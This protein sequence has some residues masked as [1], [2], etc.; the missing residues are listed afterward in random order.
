[1]NANMPKIPTQ[2]LDDANSRQL[3]NIAEQIASVMSEECNEVI[4]DDEEKTI[5]NGFHCLN[6]NCGYPDF[7]EKRFERGEELGEWFQSPHECNDV[8]KYLPKRA[9]FFS[10]LLFIYEITGFFGDYYF[11]NIMRLYDDYYIFSLDE[12]ALNV[13]EKVV[14]KDQPKKLT[15]R[16][17]Y[18]QVTESNGNKVLRDIDFKSFEINPSFI[19]WPHFCSLYKTYIRN[20]EKSFA[21]ED[22]IMGPFR[23][24]QRE[25]LFKIT[26]EPE[27]ELLKT[28][29]SDDFYYTNS[30]EPLK[31]QVIDLYLELLPVSEKK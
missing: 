14:F 20:L 26:P 9:G 8:F 17:F 1:M 10:E 23:E 21:N 12:Y 31:D 11:V 6:D 18:H 5:Y 3:R 16:A 19:D 7:L 25:Y 28:V 22:I 2:P 13:F 4:L 24:I 30:P 27:H 15:E 29:L